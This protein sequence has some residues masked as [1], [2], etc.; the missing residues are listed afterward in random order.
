DPP[1]NNYGAANRTKWLQL[2]EREL[3][4]FLRLARDQIVALDD[5]GAGVPAQESVVV[6]GR[7]NRF[8]FL[9]PIHRFAQKIISLKPAIRRVRAKFCLSPTLGHDPGVIKPVVIRFHSRKELFR[10]GVA[11]G[12]AFFESIGEREQ[13]YDDRLLI[14]ALSLQDIETDA[15]RFARL[16]K[17]TVSFGFLQRRWDSFPGQMF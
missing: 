3:D 13:K 6:A 5:P 14:L 9:E 12:V 4:S 16:V 8:R 15:F 17:Q 11:D 1:P 10:L 7:T 2:F